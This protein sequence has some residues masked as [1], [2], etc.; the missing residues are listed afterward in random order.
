MTGPGPLP[1]PGS[2]PVTV[3]SP[4]LPPKKPRLPFLIIPLYLHETSG[5]NQKVL[6]LGRGVWICEEASFWGKA[7]V[8]VVI[9]TNLRIRSDLP[10]LPNTTRR[11]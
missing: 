11:V 3:P 1:S 2:D 8:L 6:E 9:P 10:P 5:V 7:I 4:N